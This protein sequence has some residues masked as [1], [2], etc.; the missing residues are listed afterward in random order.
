MARTYLNLILITVLMITATSCKPR[1]S[2]QLSNYPYKVEKIDSLNNYY[3][4][5]ILNSDKKY[6]I[7]SKKTKSNCNIIKVNQTYPS[8]IFEPLIKENDYIP[9]DRPAN[10][11]DFVPNKI[12]LDDSTVI[13]KG[14]D[15]DNIFKTNN[16]NGLCYID[17]TPK[18]KIK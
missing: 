10:Y 16:L 13:A 6:Q 12:I 17:L 3:I 5:Y 15:Q 8:F 1:Q 2:A 4:I 18:L 11:L 7:V 14:K 9:K